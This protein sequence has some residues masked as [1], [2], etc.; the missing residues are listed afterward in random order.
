MSS[1]LAVQ[2]PAPQTE[3]PV[4]RSGHAPDDHL[5]SGRSVLE[6]VIALIMLIVFFRNFVAE[7]YL[8]PSGSMAPSLLGFH[9][10]VECP[11]CHQ[12][13]A[14]GVEE[15]NQSPHSVVCINCGHPQIEV[16][17][18]PMNAGDRLLVH[19]WHY[20]FRAPR[21]WE[22]VVF[23]NPNDSMQ[24]YVKR[25]VGLPGEKVRIFDGDI[26]VDGQIAR[27]E[28]DQFLELC[29]PVHYDRKPK[30]GVPVEERWMPSSPGSQWEMVD[31]EFT[32]DASKR[33]TVDELVYRHRDPDGFESPVRDDCSYNLGR[34]MWHHDLV[35][36]LLLRFIAVYHSGNGFLEVKLK[37]PGG[38]VFIARFDPNERT[39]E[40]SLDG[41]VVRSGKTEGWNASGQPMSVGFFDQRLAVRFGTEAP[42]DDYDLD[43]RLE[44]RSTPS[45]GSSQPL[46]IGAADL[47][48][49]V[50]EMCIDRDIFYGSKVLDNYDPAAVRKPFPL[51]GDEYFVLGDN[52][53]IS[54]DSR[55]WEH[56]AIPGSML[57]GKPILVHLPSQTW[58]GRVFGRQIPISLPDIGNVRRVK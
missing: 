40:L 10:R 55:V 13:F 6:F 4:D 1:G 34:S 39:A 32:I 53:P 5:P 2:T 8:V 16:G 24:A 51:A 26:Y 3:A 38:N 48:L 21:R 7:A 56:P 14:V 28:Y 25:V 58:Q 20:S 37:T 12:T 35:G 22:T 23:R 46:S 45:F 31:R 17:T 30:P 33:P 49:S 36:D 27:K 18:L 54:N 44:A 42:F 11:S 52:S 29:L 9:K 50:K 19:K 41:K 57:I 47:K 43:G 15:N